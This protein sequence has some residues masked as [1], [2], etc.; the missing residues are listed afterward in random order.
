MPKLLSVVLAGAVAAAA[1]GAASVASAGRQVHGGDVARVMAGRAF[2]IQCV[3]GTRGSGQFS[4]HGVVTVNYRR[5]NSAEANDRAVVRVRGVEICLAWKQFG[6][7][8]DGC[9][10]VSEEAVGTYRLGTGPM[11]CDISASK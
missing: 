6:G 7:G 8:G 10:P 3:D 5:P 1:I 2:H 11:W 4:Q 9:Y